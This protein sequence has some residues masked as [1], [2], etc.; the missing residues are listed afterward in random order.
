MNNRLTIT[1]LAGGLG[2]RMKSPLPKVLHAV[3]GTPMLVMV[4]NEAIKLNP[5]KIIIVVG[6][7]RPIIEDVIKT[8]DLIKHVVFAI[9]EPALGTGHA[10]L[11]TLDQLSNSNTDY[12]IILNGDSPFL[13][14]NTI[15]DIIRVFEVNDLDLQ[16]TSINTPNPHGCGR[17]I[18]DD[19][20]L[21]QRIVEER[22]CTSD[23]RNIT[24]VNI[25]IYIAKNQTLKKF[26]PMI[27]NIN[28]QNEYYL[29]DIVELYKSTE[30][31]PVGLIEL[32]SSKLHEIANINTIEQLNEFNKN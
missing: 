25:G 30:D 23:Q 31:K 28:S 32:P 11:C 29:T 12:N 1:I 5:S 8:Y 22:D 3:R 20:G 14:A 16:I 26:I 13:S 17:I 6:Q 18:K 27:K 10:V 9:Q 2:K 7:Y 19:K 4:I 24:E 15:S 21:F